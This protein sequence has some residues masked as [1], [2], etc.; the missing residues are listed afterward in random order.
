VANWRDRPVVCFRG[1][2]VLENISLPEIGDDLDLHRVAAPGGIGFVHRGFW[3]ALATLWPQIAVLLP[4][5]ASPIFTGHSLGGARAHLASALLPG[6]AVTFGAPK[7]ADEPFWAHLYSADR[8]PPLRILHEEDFA[9]GWS[10]LLPWS[11]HP[12][13]EI[14]WLHSGRL[15]RVPERTT[16]F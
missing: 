13:G 12:S 10:P 5:D 8:T 11:T 6:E 3:T 2:Q 16:W 14:G 4:A 1:T 15:Y 7:A 9:P